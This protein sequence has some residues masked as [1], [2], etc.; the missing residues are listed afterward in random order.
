MDADGFPRTPTM[1]FLKCLF[2]T[3]SYANSCVNPFVYAFLSDGFRKSFRKTFPY[4]AHKYK[5]CGGPSEDYASQAGMQERPVDHT[6]ATM[7]VNMEERQLMQT[8]LW[9]LYNR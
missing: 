3:L 5:I 4:L 1:F 2:H 9:K 7:T 6:K 8:D